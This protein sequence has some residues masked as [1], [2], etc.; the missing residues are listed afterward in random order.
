MYTPAHFN[1]SDKK[2]ISK[3]VNDYPLATVLSYPVGSDVFINHLPLMFDPANS[4][5][6]LGH[7][8][9]RN[10]QWEHFRTSQKATVIIQGPHAYITPSWYRSGRD[11]PTWNYAVAH[12]HG[13]VELIEDFKGQ[14]KVIKTMSE[15]FERNLSNPW[16]FSLPDDLKTEAALTGAIVSF[17]FVIEKI[18]AKFKLSQNRGEEDREG[19][20]QGLLELGDEQSLAVRELMTTK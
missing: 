8:A 4:E 13:H 10:P 18:E 17:R 19:V 11:V 12:L 2:A 14:V 20:R 6:M 15:H 1:I 5:V 3:L 16:K 9:R 7:M